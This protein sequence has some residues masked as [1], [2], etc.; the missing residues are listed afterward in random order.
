MSLVVRSPE[1]RFLE[2]I[3]SVFISTEIR[4]GQQPIHLD[5][6]PGCQVPCSLSLVRSLT[7]SYKRAWYIIKIPAKP[8][9]AWSAKNLV[10]RGWHYKRYSIIAITLCYVFAWLHNALYLWR[11]VI[12][13]DSNRFRLFAGIIA[14]DSYRPV[15]AGQRYCFTSLSF[16]VTYAGVVVF[17][18]V[19]ALIWRWRCPVQELYFLLQNIQKNL[20]IFALSCNALP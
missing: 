14:Y 2:A 8:I 19:M 17:R 13:S 12:A 11:I 18:E 20:V 1:M 4:S 15:L 3:S 7:M 5:Q 16:W 9:P 6:V 10:L